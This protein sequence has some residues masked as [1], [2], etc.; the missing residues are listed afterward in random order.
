MRRL[1]GL[2]SLRLGGDLSLRLSYNNISDRSS[3]HHFSSLLGVYHI[4]GSFFAVMMIVIAADHHKSSID[5]KSGDSP[6]EACM[7]TCCRL[8]GV[9]QTYKGDGGYL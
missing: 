6:R 3:R 7:K 8:T 4:E 9:K 1:Y 5:R 2:R